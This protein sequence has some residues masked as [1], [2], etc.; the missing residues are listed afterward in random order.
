MRNRWP[1]VADLAVTPGANDCQ[2]FPRHTVRL[3]GHTKTSGGVLAVWSLTQQTCD[4]SDITACIKTAKRR[5]EP[6]GMRRLKVATLGPAER[7]VRPGNFY[8]LHLG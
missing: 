3:V 7:A 4:W 6:R 1:T 8:E 5:C 2:L